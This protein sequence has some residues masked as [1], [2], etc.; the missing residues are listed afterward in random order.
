M[1]TTDS[2]LGAT[3]TADGVHFSA[4]SG[5]ATK[6]WVCLFDGQDRETHR[7]PLA[8]LKDGVFSAQIPG[9]KAGQRY[10]LRADGDYAPQRGLWYDPDKLLIDPYAVEIDRPCRYDRR[11]SLPRGEAGDTAPLMPKAIVRSLPDTKPA[12]PV[13]AAAGLIYELQVKAFTE[14]HPE[15]PEA[16]RGT[17]AA[18]R[19]PAIIA[20]L[21][22]LHV[23][24][25]ELMPVTAW[26]DERHL[27][28]LGLTNAW[29]Y[30]P[31]TFMAPDPRLCPGGI[32]ELRD[33]VAALHAE[34]IG[35]I[36]DLVFN[37]SAESDVSGPTLSMRGLDANSYYRRKGRR[38][39]N[40]AGTGNTIACDH[41]AVR[42]LVLDSLR[43]F[44]RHAG[45]DGFRFDLAPI[46]GRDARGFDPNAALLTAMVEDPLLRDR[47][48]IAEPWD[49]GAGGYQLGNFR[50]PWLEWNDRYRDD[51]RRFW[52]GDRNM[53]G[54]LATR[55]AGSSDV[56]R[57]DGEPTTRTVNFIAAHD[58][59]T[60]ADVTAFERKHNLAN[61]E[62]NRDGHNEN[63]SWNN[64]VE[65]PTGDAR[66]AAARR[67]D[68]RALL[69]TLFVSRGAIMLT[70]GDEFGRTQG[71]N[72]NA[73]CQDN[74]T[75]WLDWRGRDM[76]LE[77][78]VA[79]L[80]RLRQEEPALVA[81]AF[82]NGQSAAAGPPDVVWLTEA[83]AAIDESAWNDAERRRLVM[84][85]ASGDGRLAVI[86]NGD[87]LA[88]T[89]HLP[90]RQGFTWRLL[91]SDD[92]PG[93]V[94]GG[95]QVQGRTVELMRECK[96]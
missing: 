47:I 22:K 70:A 41:P 76:Q 53:V 49:I 38:L 31:V 16:A 68:R 12:K 28:S 57:R 73:Y 90:V 6:L 69:A 92:A 59:M 10:G 64:G 3:V 42:R 95:L 17:V 93:A 37:H 7:L 56:F 85:L 36:L 15:V 79:A 48:L 39:V 4:W 35:V 20:H 11:L 33:T 62:K 89:F 83:G 18:L 77:A 72:N 27:L 63:L 54:Q 58:G 88:T 61:G 2:P 5:H 65:G 51:I 23:S 86:I 84:L 87:H 25:V 71:G 94:A 80:A 66:I 46:L 60:L 55:L 34:G 9:L 29:G 13:F 81:T 45:V 24:A 44:V 26:M 43:H 74:E 75:T 8:R 19:H 67:R 32:A 21:K 14:L 96:L 52:R 40:D 30:N 1:K 78:Y 82:L 50:A 91:H